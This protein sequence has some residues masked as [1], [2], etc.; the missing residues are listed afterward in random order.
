MIGQ[1]I[2]ELRI[3]SDLT[4]KE[5]SE[6]LGLTPKMISFYELG[7]RFPPNDILMKLS[8]IFGVTTD[9]L[10]GLADTPAPLDAKA[11]PVE[12]GTLALQREFERLGLKKEGEDLT[13]KELSV[14][15]E[16]FEK[17]ADFIKARMEQL[18][19]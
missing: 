13:D 17:N 11:P 5:L 18:E 3:K 16:Y 2:K 8:E 19:D 4:Q 7:E 6:K 9:Y 14:L 10:L 1:R 15:L 12:Q